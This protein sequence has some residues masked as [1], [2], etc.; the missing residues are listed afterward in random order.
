MHSPASNIDKGLYEIKWHIRAQC[1]P[2]P[3]KC[4]NPHPPG[5]F[6]IFPTVSKTVENQCKNVTYA[7][8][9]DSVSLWPSRR[10]LV[11]W[12]HMCSSQTCPHERLVEQPIWHRS[13]TPRKTG[14]HFPCKWSN[15]ILHSRT[16]L[17]GQKTFLVQRNCVGSS[18]RIR[19]IPCTIS[20][21]VMFVPRIEKIRNH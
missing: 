14:I 7:Q 10:V 6:D 11:L 2:S 4:T 8:P 9:E 5:V 15:N 13:C 1:A 20:P 21:S 17:E 19:G 18:G 3:L 16:V 12:P